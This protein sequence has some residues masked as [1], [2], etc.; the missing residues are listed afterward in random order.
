[1]IRADGTFLGE[2]KLSDVT[3]GDLQLSEHH[4]IRLRLGIDEDVGQPGGINVFGRG[5]GN[6]NQDIKMR[7]H[8][9]GTI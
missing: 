8:L 9:A 7:M 2:Q 1:M 3:I 6:F 5:F 4:S